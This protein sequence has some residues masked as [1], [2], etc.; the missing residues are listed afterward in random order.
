[1]IATTT[2]IRRKSFTTNAR[3]CRASRSSA[4]DGSP[5]AR[6]DVVVGEIEGI[7]TLRN[8]VV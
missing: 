6:G 1:M 8:P 5:A 4:A 7:G 3:S 2:P